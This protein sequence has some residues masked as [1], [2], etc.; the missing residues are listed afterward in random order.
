ILRVLLGLAECLYLPAA[1]GLLAD[2]HQ[3]DTRATALGIHASGL[4]FGM[5]A[6]GT[7]SGYLGERFG[8]RPAFF[9]LGTLG[10][11][12]AGIAAI[13]LQE[14]GE[15]ETKREIAEPRFAAIFALA[16]IPSYGV[17]LVEAALVAIGTWIFANWLPL[18]FRETYRLTLAAAGFSGTFSS[19]VG[20]VSGVMIGGYLSDRGARRNV[21]QRLL[22]LGG[23]FMLS[24][25]FLVVFLATP[26]IASRGASVRLQ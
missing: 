12:L 18:Y 21:R 7:A 4:S 20:V 1:L 16:N 10:L 15:S 24:G 6:G 8:W 23:C 22:V 19:T 13:W 3:S 26:S 11:A 17:I 9:M 14:A 2:Y 25:A 5:I